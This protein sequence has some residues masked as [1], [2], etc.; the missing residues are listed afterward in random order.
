MYFHT[1]FLT[2][3][4]DHTSFMDPD[5]LQCILSCFS[6]APISTVGLAE[7]QKKNCNEKMIFFHNPWQ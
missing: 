4:R 6:P 3:F 7:S 2:F 1:S 5:P